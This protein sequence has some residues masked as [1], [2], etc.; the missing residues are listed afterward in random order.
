MI[1]LVNENE[2]DLAMFESNLSVVS[3]MDGTMIRLLD[4][5]NK[6]LIIKMLVYLISRMNDNYNMNNKLNDNQIILLSI[7]LLDVFSYE[8]IEDVV[9][10]FKLARRG[11]LGTKI[12]RLDSQIIFQEW[13]PTYLE[14]KAV[15]REKQHLEV[16]EKNKIDFNSKSNWNDESKKNLRKL[17]N[18]ISIKKEP[19]KN[20]VGAMKNKKEFIKELKVNCKRM[21][22]KSLKQVIEKWSKMVHYTDYMDIL[23]TELKNRNI[24]STCT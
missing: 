3:A 18:K 23:K 6:K 19:K 15:E 12:Y 8:T 10:M 24:L 4:R 5:Q 22:K 16:K 20:N 14:L 7:D 2:N 17:I 11:Q 9:M 21:S 1:I 13:V